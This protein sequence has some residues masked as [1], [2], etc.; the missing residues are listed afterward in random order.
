MFGGQKLT[1]GSYADV[2]IALADFLDDEGSLDIV[3]SDIAAALICLVNIQKQKQIDCKHQLLQQGG[4]FAKDRKLADR[5]WKQFISSD[6]SHRGRTRKSGSAASTKETLDMK[7]A[8]DVESGGQEDAL[9]ISQ[10]MM[11]AKD[12]GGE[13]KFSIIH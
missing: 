12:N 5:L 7:M 3:T 11:K 9:N 4:L 2:A 1:A 8:G 13:I 6:T 10:S